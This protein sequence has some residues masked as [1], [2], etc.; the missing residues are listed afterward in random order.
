ML[1]L[2]CG[3]MA[4][5]ASET[6]SGYSDRVG[7]LEAE[8]KVLKSEAKAREKAFR[9]ELALIRKNLESIR[10]LMEVGQA[11]G[12]VQPKAKLDAVPED[13]TG[14]EGDSLDEQIDTQAKTF[15]KENLG[16]LLEI[17][18]KLLDKMEFELDK[19]LKEDAESGSADGEKI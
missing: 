1:V 14:T 16:R 18:K 5:C 8:V 11:G 15:V 3:L 12:T 2:T 7:A 19:Q 6:P 4:G 9:E 10:A 17:T 13:Q